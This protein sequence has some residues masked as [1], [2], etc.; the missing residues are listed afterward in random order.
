MGGSFPKHNVLDISFPPRPETCQQPHTL[1]WNGFAYSDPFGPKCERSTKQHPQLSLAQQGDSEG[2]HQEA[3]RFRKHHLSPRGGGLVP[4]LAT[5][6]YQKREALYF[7]SLLSESHHWI[8][9]LAEEAQ[10]HVGQR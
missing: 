5:P 8:Q 10:K 2:Q 6:A 4:F 3:I 7:I 9:Y 1:Q